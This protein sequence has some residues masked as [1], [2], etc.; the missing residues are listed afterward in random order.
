VI[1]KSFWEKEVPEKI[2]NSL[3][4]ITQGGFHK[5]NHKSVEI[6][7]VYNV[8]CPQFRPTEWANQKKGIHGNWT[9]DWM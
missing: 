9:C 7:Y 8:S 5:N 4:R 1:K 2:W 3:P 6:L